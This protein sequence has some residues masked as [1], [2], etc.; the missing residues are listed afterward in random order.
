[1]FDDGRPFTSDEIVIDP[2]V[3][4]AARRA[5]AD[6]YRAGQRESRIPPSGG[7]RWR[8]GQAAG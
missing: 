7:A 2:A 6:M 3:P 8:V 5:L 1:M 4:A